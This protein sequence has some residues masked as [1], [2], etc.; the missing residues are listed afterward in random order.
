M[1][2]FHVAAPEPLRY[3]MILPN[4]QPLR[5]DMGPEYTWDGNV[6]ASAYPTLQPP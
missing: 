5:W 1:S 2:V 4:G 3:D 6:P